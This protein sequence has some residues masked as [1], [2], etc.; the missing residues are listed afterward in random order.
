[1]NDI[2]RL[3]ERVMILNHEKLMFDDINQLRQHIGLPT[4]LIC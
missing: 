2:K 4:E 1:M 3:A